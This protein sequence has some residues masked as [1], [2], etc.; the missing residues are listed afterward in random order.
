MTSFR[1]ML[2]QAQ[3]D[4][5]IDPPSNSLP[6]WEGERALNSLLIDDVNKANGLYNQT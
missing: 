1:E 4:R 5:S 3:H 2:N 6:G